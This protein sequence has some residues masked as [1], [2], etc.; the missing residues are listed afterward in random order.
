MIEI[1]MIACAYSGLVIGFAL[2]AIGQDVNND[3]DKD[4]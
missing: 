3:W 2:V 1:Y 4:V